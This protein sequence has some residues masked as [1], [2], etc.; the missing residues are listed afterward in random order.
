M[1]HYLGD[2]AVLD[3]F[4]SSVFNSALSPIHACSELILNTFPVS[5][6]TY[7]KCE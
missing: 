6:F 7:S 5:N 3:P 2:K 1:T 4:L